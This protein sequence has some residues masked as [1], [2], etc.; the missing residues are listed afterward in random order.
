MEIVHRTHNVRSYRFSRSADFQYKPGQF[1]YVTIRGANG[2]LSKPY[3]ISSSPTEKD[4]IEFTKKLSSSEYSSTLD[5]L[6]I[7][8]WARISGPYGNFTFE[9]EHDRIGLLSGGIGI[10]P[11][12]SI[13]KY[14]T[15]LGLGTDIILL[16][17]NQSQTDIAFME[18]LSEMQE[19]NANLRVEYTID[20]PSPDWTGRVGYIDSRMIMDV[21]P[22]YMNRVFYTCGPAAMVE[23]IQEELKE[24]GV[25]EKQIRAERFAA[26]SIAYNP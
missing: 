24:I 26:N 22:D 18:D 2:E 10:T 4:H 1:T 14:C 6:K 19:R 21:I 15:D 5:A 9:G 3:S 25:S 23:A 7:G 20:R 13:C 8:D 16:Y 11:L 17:G 12:R